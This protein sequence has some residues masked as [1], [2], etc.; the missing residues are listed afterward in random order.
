MNHEN[1]VVRPHRRLVEKYAKPE[2]WTELPPKAMAELSDEIAGLPAEIDQENEEAKRFDLLVLSLQLALLRSASCFVRLRDRLKQI[3]S[4]LENKSAIPMIQARMVL[5]QDMQTDEWWQ[6]VTVPMLEGLRRRLRDLIELIDK[7]QRKSVYTDFEDLIGR[8]TEV[9]LGSFAAGTGFR[10]FPREGAGLS[11]A[12]PRPCRDPQ[13][14]VQ[15]ASNSG[16]S[17]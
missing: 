15:Q 4:F 2:A 17:R 8:G 3:A 5:I 1:F 9:E 7:R 13:A 12:A 11:A 16:R 6:D 14:A 10:E